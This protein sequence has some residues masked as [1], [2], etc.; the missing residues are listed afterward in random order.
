MVPPHR[1]DDAQD[2]LT[3]DTL[4]PP[5][6]PLPLPRPIIPRQHTRRVRLIKLL[7]HQLVMAGT[8]ATIGASPTRIKLLGFARAVSRCV[9][10]SAVFDSDA[11]RAAIGEVFTRVNDTADEKRED[12]GAEKEEDA[13]GEGVDNDA[14]A[15]VTKMMLLRSR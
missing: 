10:L 7:H 9:S 11:A 6:L 5:L 15:E 2:E 12:V 14:A 1:H 4:H 8:V 3:L 13:G